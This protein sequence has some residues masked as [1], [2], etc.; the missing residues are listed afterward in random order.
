MGDFTSGSR[1]DWGSRHRS[2]SVADHQGGG[3]DG[4]LFS[5]YG[6]LA[7]VG[8]EGN[9]LADID[10]TAPQVGDTVFATR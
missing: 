9:R 5:S 1:A 3:I 4:S 6:T 2:Q 7:P 10:I 8:G